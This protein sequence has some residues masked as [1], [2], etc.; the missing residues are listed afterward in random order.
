M[1]INNIIVAAQA[2]GGVGLFLLGIIIMTD[3]LRQLAGDAIRSALMRFTHNPLSG[4]LTGA[5]STAILQSSSATTVAAVGFVGAGLMN[6]PAALGIIFG[7]NVGTT[8]KGWIVVLLGFKLQIGTMVLPLIFIGTIMRLFAKGRLSTVGYALAGFGLIFVGITTLQ[9]GMA[10][11]QGIVTPDSFPRN[12]FLG[13]LTLVGI[14]ILSTIITQS[15]SAGVL[16]ALTALYVGA[17]EFEQAAALVIGM[18]MGTTVTAALATVGGSVAARRTGFSHVIY[19]LFTG[20]GAIILITPYTFIWEVIAP[21]QLIKNAEMALVAFHTLFNT[22]GVI[23]VLPFTNKF[24]R[25]MERLIPEKGLA[26]TNKLDRALLEQ[27]TL[28]LNAVQDAVY[29]QMMAL[30]RH[31]AA[32]LGDSEH[33]KRVDLVELQIALDETHTYIDQIHLGAGEGADWER[34]LALIHTLDHLQRLH[35]RC[36]EEE[37]RA[38]TAKDSEVLRE[39]S[40]LLAE[41]VSVVIDDIERGHWKSAVSRCDKTASTLHDHEEPRRNQILGQ[42]AIDK[43]DVPTATSLLEAMR[44]LKRVSKHIHRIVL[45]YHQSLI[46]AGK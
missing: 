16:A 30:F 1:V 41:T 44:W 43:I 13:V 21:G 18:D 25:L 19:N 14:G 7:A 39:D 3:G 27:P 34:M 11:L 45:H 15:S 22:L 42:A 12:T 40:V 4:A 33:G 28:A 23:A 35:E 9:E 29:I 26:Y 46:A 20:V 24:A 36:E 8:F 2:L 10:G 17:I 32:I 38:I 31:L 5:A 6:F 37:V